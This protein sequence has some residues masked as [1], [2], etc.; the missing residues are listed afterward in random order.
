MGLELGVAALEEGGPFAFGSGTGSVTQPGPAWGLRLGVDVLS[1]LGFEGRYIGAYSSG[2]LPENV[3]FLMTGGEAVVRLTLPT[4]YVRPYIFGGI[5]VYDFA[6]L[7]SNA[8][9]A[10][11]MLNSSTQPGVPMGLG[12]ELMLSWHVSFAVEA[13]YRFQIGESFSRND[14]IGGADLTTFTGVMRF[15][16]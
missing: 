8:A 11:S 10:A 12:V 3:G 7:G 2:N 1:W 15:R 5:G 16:L 4:P 6:L 13:T 9:V 14:T